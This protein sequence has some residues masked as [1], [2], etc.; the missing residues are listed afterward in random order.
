MSL[1]KKDHYNWTNNTEILGIPSDTDDDSLED[2][3]IEMLTEV[4]I[5]AKKSDI[6]VC[7]RLDKNGNTIYDL[8]IESSI[9]IFLGK[10]IDLNKNTEKP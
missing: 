6:E 7:H 1:I 3:V 4:H 2:K 8:S 5:L 10:K 9:M